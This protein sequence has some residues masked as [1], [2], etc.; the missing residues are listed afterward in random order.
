MWGAFLS[1]PL[2]IVA[3]VGR[4]P[5]VKLIGRTAIPYRNKSLVATPCGD[6][7]TPGINPAFAGLFPSTG[8][9]RYA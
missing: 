7:T 9:V 5:A 1:E 8:Q 2:P 4:H 6:A 3:T